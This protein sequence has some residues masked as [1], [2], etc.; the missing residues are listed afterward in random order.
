MDMTRTQVE[1]HILPA[2]DLV[3]KGSKLYD[4]GLKAM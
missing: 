3:E 1:F 4:L 2:P